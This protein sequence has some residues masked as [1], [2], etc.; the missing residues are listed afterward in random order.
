MFYAQK[1][2][3]SQDQSQRVFVAL[4]ILIMMIIYHL[5]CPPYPECV[6]DGAV[7]YMDTSD[8]YEIGDMN[9]DGAINVIDIVMTVNL[10]LNGSYDATG[11]VNADEQLNVLDVVMLVN[12]VLNGGPSEFGCTGESSCNY[13][14]DATVDDGSCIY[15]ESGYDCDGWCLDDNDGDLICDEDDV[16]DDNDNCL[17][18]NDDAPLI[19]DDDYDGDGI[20]D[21]CDDDDDNDGTY[22][23]ADSDDNNEYV[24]SDIDGDTC[25]DCSSGTFDT[26]N[27]GPDMNGNGICDEGESEND[28]DGDGVIDDE[29]SDPYNQYQCSDNDG[30]TCDDCSSGHYDTSDDGYDYDAD[31]QCDAGDCDDDN[32]GCQECW[33]YCP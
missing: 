13:D 19:W 7:N 23:A 33:D 3:I 6:P 1:S 16:D 18:D 29:D 31:G 9:Y 2:T 8:C 26:A 21:D 17:D 15:P 25:E 14:P 4:K 5:I 28:S 11:D 20:P 27:D 10:I 22:D 32:D 30:D 12:W 24:C